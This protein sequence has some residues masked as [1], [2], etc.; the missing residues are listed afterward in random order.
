MKTAYE[1][2]YEWDIETVDEHDDITDHRH[3]SK[4]RELPL[5]GAGE[6]LVLVCS[7]YRDDED[8]GAQ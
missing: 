6:R 4:L 2:A 1:T 3:A 7:V 8:G 5:C